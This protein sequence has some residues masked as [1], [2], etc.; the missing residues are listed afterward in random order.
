MGIFDQFA[1]DPQ[2]YNPVNPIAGLLQRLPEWQWQNR[3]GGE[4]PQIGGE[5]LPAVAPQP[6]MPRA[7]LDI[8]PQAPM[9]AAAQPQTGGIG[10]IFN[11][12]SNSIAENPMTLMALGAGIMQ[13]GF[14]KGLQLAMAG[15]EMDK[16]SLQTRQAQNATIAALKAKGFSDAEVALAVSSPDAMKAALA[17][18]M[19][20]YSAHNV[21]GTGGAFNPATGEFKPQ[22]VEPKIEKMQPGESIYQIGGPPQGERVATPVAGVQP[23]GAKIGDV[24]EM[25][26]E[27]SALPEV[28]RFSEAVPIFRSMVATHNRTPGFEGASDLDFVYG[29]AKI[30]DPDSVVREG[31]MKLVG[32]ANTLP[33]DV[34][35]FIER[36][37]M[38]GGALSPEARARILNVAQTRMNEL[39]TGYDARVNPYSD[40]AT[41]FNIRPADVVPTVPALPEYKPSYVAPGAAKGVKKTSTGIEWSV[42]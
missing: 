8:I 22:F 41:R 3:G 15:S 39:K 24:S 16:K 30:F 26:K 14:G 32:K 11:G 36:V 5:Q 7:P 13:G 20:T 1:F 42:Q 2:T 35:A 17:K 33:D 38:G 10:G 6:Q 18:I 19:P 23:M 4:F 27:I 37:S 29:V 34:K 31:E 40:I 12:L 21:G 25:R 9:L 28:K